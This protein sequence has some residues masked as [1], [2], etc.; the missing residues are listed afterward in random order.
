M[1]LPLFATQRQLGP[2]FLDEQ[3]RARLENDARELA[4]SLRGLGPGAQ[5]TLFAELARVTVPVLLVAGELDAAFA[6]A[7]RDLARHLPNAATC[8]IAG[9]GHAPHLERPDAVLTVV[10]H[11]LRRVSARN[12][13]SPLQPHQE[14]A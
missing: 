11:F 3:R 10:R 12:P 1:A 5:P 4:A 7:S 9:A 2:A 6:A 13:T 8:E 14:T